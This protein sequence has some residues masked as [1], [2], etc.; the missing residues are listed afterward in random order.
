MFFMFEGNIIYKCIVVTS[1]KYLISELV[2]DYNSVLSK[3]NIQFKNI[4]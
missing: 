1:T 3:V 4:T 2:Q